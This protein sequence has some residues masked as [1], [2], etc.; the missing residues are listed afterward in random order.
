MAPFIDSVAQSVLC[1]ALMYT[2]SILTNLLYPPSCLLCQADLSAVDGDASQGERHAPVLCQACRDAIPDNGP[3]VCSQC[4]ADVPGAFDATFLCV[5]CCK[6]RLAFEMARAPWQYAGSSQEAIRQFKYHRRWR[7]GRWLA[8]AMI[9]TARR[10]FPLDDITLVVPVPLHWVKRRVK[11]FQPVDQLASTVAEA[12][13]KPYRPQ[14]LRRRR[15]T[16]TQTHLSRGRRFQN[17]AKAFAAR[18][19]LVQDHG[20]LLVD[21]V[22]TSGAT[23]HACTIA[24][25]DAGARRVFVLTAARTP[26]A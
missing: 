4:G 21:D 23:A 15:W 3:P 7:I 10:S 5:S 19:H 6:N 11:G 16:T 25:Q 14:A 20:V 8:E 13:E 17:V 12:L 22:F 18:P 24:L 2:R 26:L 1:C 9:Q